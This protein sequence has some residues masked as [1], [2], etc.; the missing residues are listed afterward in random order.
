MSTELSAKE[1]ELKGISELNDVLNEL[2][3]TTL[4]GF[5]GSLFVNNRIDICAVEA[6]GHLTAL[7]E[8]LKAMIVGIRSEIEGQKVGSDD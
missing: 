3:T 7:K 6:R 5:D 8:T 2:A 1:V 4:H